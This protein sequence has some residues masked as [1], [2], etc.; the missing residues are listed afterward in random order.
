MSNMYEPDYD[1]YTVNEVL[2]RF[3]FNN[4]SGFYCQYITV[5]LLS[6]PMNIPIPSRVDDFSE[7]KIHFTE[8]HPD[9]PFIIGS[10][11]RS[12]FGSRSQAS[13]FTSS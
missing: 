8:K 7:F 1:F 2:N 13:G 9:C 12:D 10:I 3:D 5:S 4:I 6:Q 11:L